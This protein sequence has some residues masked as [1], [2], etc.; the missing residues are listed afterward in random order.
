MDTFKV[1]LNACGNEVLASLS[2]DLIDRSH[3]VCDKHFVIEEKSRNNRLCRGVVPKLFL[4]ESAFE[5]A[6][7]AESA[8]PTIQFANIPSIS[9]VGANIENVPTIQ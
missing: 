7:V 3:R 2:P 9:T 1:W 5:I 8:T 6:T 4:P